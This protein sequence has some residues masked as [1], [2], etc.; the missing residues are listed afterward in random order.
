VSALLQFGVVLVLYGVPTFRIRHSCYSEPDRSAIDAAE[1]V[2]DVVV[3]IGI[4]SSGLR[5]SP[6]SF[7]WARIL[8]LWCLRVGTEPLGF[9]LLRCSIFIGFH[10]IDR[11]EADPFF[12]PFGMQPK[13]L[14][15]RTLQIVS[16]I[17]LLLVELL[18]CGLR[19]HSVQSSM[20]LSRL[21]LLRFHRHGADRFFKGRERS[22]SLLLL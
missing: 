8:F 4:A 16:R 7:Q 14:V 1:V 6:C 12:K 17:L 20:L 21:L 10:R 9:I 18:Q 2:F 13:A 15:L 22:V 11:H 3:A 19:W 5:W